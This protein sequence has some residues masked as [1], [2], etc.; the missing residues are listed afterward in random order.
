V[1]ALAK[2]ISSRKS[3]VN[4]RAYYD[5]LRIQAG[6]PVRYPVPEALKFLHKPRKP[7]TAANAVA[8]KPPTPRPAP[9]AGVPKSVLPPARRFGPRCLMKYG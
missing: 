5:M 6:L 3:A 2:P 4:L 7:R 9:A 1:A 8:S